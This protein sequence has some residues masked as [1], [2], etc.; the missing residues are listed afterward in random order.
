[1]KEYKENSCR[2]NE[3]LDRLDHE[4]KRMANRKPTSI[5]QELASDWQ[6]I[7]DSNLAKKPLKEM[8]WA[9]VRALSGQFVAIACKAWDNVEFE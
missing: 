7:L 9:E 4:L 8:S 1:M 5:E 2:L 3:A 6:A